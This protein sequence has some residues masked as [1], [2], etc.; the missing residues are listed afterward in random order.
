MC[1]DGGEKCV[2]ACM[3]R[4]KECVS[5]PVPCRGQFGLELLILPF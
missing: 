4:E 2:G 3:V 1:T 5:N